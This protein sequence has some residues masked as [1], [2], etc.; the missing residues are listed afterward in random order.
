MLRL[1][2]RQAYQR[3]LGSSEP[4][5][6]LLALGGKAGLQ[7]GEGLG[8]LGIELIESPLE[9]RPISRGLLVGIVAPGIGIGSLGRRFLYEGARA[10]GASAGVVRLAAA[11][12]PLLDEGRALLLLLRFPHV[13]THRR[14]HRRRALLRLRLLRA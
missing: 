14:P 1:A 13:R 5:L 3:R 9:F 10:V 7:G 12:K 2:S 6:D 8:L 4:G 11:T